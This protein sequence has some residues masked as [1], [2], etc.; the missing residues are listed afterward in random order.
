[1]TWRA[2]RSSSATGIALVL[3]GALVAACSSTPPPGLAGAACAED[4]DCGPDERCFKGP[5]FPG[6]YCARACGEDPEACPGACAVAAGLPLCLGPCPPEGCRDGYHCF[7]DGC[8]PA[9]RTGA[10]CGEGASCIR[11]FCQAPGCPEC[12][13][14]GVP[15]APYGAP[16]VLGSDCRSGICGTDGDERRCTVPCTSSVACRPYD[17]DDRCRFLR[18]DG[19]GDGEPD[20]AQ[21][22]CGR[23]REGL[24][25]ASRCASSAAC[26]S[27]ACV[28][29]FCA[30]V[31][32]PGAS[33][34]PGQAC[35]ETG[36][37]GLD[38]AVEACVFAPIEGPV[39][40]EVDLGV[41]DLELT[42]EEPEPTALVAVPP[43]AVSVTFQAE[44]VRANDSPLAFWQ[45]VGPE[46]QLLFDFGAVL[47]NIDPP[48][49]WLPTGAQEAV[50]LRV[51]N[52][53][54]VP[55]RA[56]RYAFSIVPTGPAPARGRYRRSVVLRRAP[57]GA[58]AAG[59][60]DLRIFLVDVGLGA[61]DAPADERLQGTLERTF[62][63]LGEA[64]VARG[65]VSY[66]ELPPEEAARFRI[67][68]LDAGSGT[69]TDLARLLRLGGDGRA[70]RVDVFLVRSIEGG[71]GFN[72]LG[73][74][75]G[76]PGPALRQGTGHSGVVVAYAPGVVGEGSFLAGTVLAH[77]LGHYLGLYHVSER[78]GPCPDDETP[79]TD[80]CSFF[81]GN[82]PIGDTEDGDR[83]NLMWWSV[84]RGGENDELSPT[85]G[86]V[87]RGAAMVR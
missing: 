53:D 13:D 34:L 8:R 10:E 67:L 29:G 54:R 7:R 80:D 16:C 6:G 79:L 17:P 22:L 52:S 87:V 19:D 5:S 68:D 3:G 42:Q 86:V 45:V 61:A 83:G 31:C 49:R 84:V 44:R 63:I 50:A 23:P 64:G 73:V 77:E 55:L 60:L 39:L 71:S 11:G 47:D 81:D 20:R 26:T 40:E 32:G 18:V 1:M 76:L 62:G 35:L 66:A 59:A 41:L 21:A 51:T 14:L 30:G 72:T 82:D 75:G 65:D 24:P 12:R 58:V 38:D 28:D 37:D 33:C 70:R 2:R 27:G 43:D 36:V 25:A 15:P 48:I 57:G 85:Q 46:E 56:G 78:L 69:D 9:C 74:A 4:T